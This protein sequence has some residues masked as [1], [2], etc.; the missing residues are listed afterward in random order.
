[1]EGLGTGM[2]CGMGRTVRTPTAVPMPGIPAAGGAQG[3]GAGGRRQGRAPRER[4]CS[5]ASRERARASG[6]QRFSSTSLL[7]CAGAEPRWSTAGWSGSLRKAGDK[8]RP[9][10]WPLNCLGKQ[11]CLSISPQGSS[12]T[13]AEAVSQAA[14][15]GTPPPLPFANDPSSWPME[16]ADL[17]AQGKDKE[18]LTTEWPFVE[19]LSWRN[20]VKGSYLMELQPCQSLLLSARDTCAI[21]KASGT[22]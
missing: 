11:I 6:L 15:P 9:C 17:Q 19:R 1:M 8:G 20:K 16:P 5:R 2:Q 22:Q 18:R 7:L 13:Q 3:A 21:G 14:C 4:L 10:I 12:L